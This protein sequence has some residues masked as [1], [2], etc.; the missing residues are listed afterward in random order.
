MRTLSDTSPS[1]VLDKLALELKMP[2]S[3][4]QGQLRRLTSTLADDTCCNRPHVNL[5]N[6]STL[7][8]SSNHLSPLAS[9]RRRPAGLAIHSSRL[10]LKVSSTPQHVL[11]ISKITLLRLKLGRKF[12]LTNM[13]GRRSAR[14]SQNKAVHSS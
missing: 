14:G 13:T 3:Q 1:F 4:I 11:V 10:K 12:R 5:N 6:H 7:K 8:Q 2:M 9:A